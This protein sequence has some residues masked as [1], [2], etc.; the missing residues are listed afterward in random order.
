M[1]NGSAHQA[2]NSAGPALSSGEG[3]GGQDNLK[4][5]LIGSWKGNQEGGVGRSSV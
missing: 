3:E 1:V 2:C 4:K 5:L